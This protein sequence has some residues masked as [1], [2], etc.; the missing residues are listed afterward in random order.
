MIKVD[1]NNYYRYLEKPLFYC[2]FSDEDNFILPTKVKVAMVVGSIK[3]AAKHPFAEN[4][5]VYDDTYNYFRVVSENGIEYWT[6]YTTKKNKS[7]TLYNSYNECVQIF[8]EEIKKF[9]DSSLEYYKEDDFPQLI[10]DLD[11][12]SINSRSTLVSSLNQFLELKQSEKI[13]IKINELLQ[14]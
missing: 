9:Y 13:N 5:D 3:Q 14:I 1:I 7:I 6:N 8:K 11:F 10:D 2:S 4:T 12:I